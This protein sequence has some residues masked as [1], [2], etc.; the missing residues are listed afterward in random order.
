M[1]A[2]NPETKTKITQ[3]RVIANKPT[4]EKKKG[5][6]KNSQY[7]QRQKKGKGTKRR[8]IKT[9]TKTTDLNPTISI[10]TLNVNG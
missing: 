7:K 9:N 3:Q 8:Q 1:Y 6:I 10:I 5:I 2:I 4:N